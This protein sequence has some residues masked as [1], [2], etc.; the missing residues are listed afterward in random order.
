MNFTQGDIAAMIGSLYMENIGLRR[1]I[2]AL[3]EQLKQK[4]VENGLPAPVD[5]GGA[6][7]T[8]IKSG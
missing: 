5:S 1:E 6:S 8:P 7:V 4:E 3:A 2:A